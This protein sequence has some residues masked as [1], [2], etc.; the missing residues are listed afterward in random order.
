MGRPLMP[1]QQYVADVALEL[2]PTTGRF[3][4]QLVLV[5]VPRQSG[6]T[7]LFG[8]VMQHRAL[9]T[10]RGRVWFTMQTQKDAVDWLTNEHWPL[11]APLGTAVS[12][13]RAIGSEAI[14]WRHSGALVRPFPPNP[15]GLHGKVSDL[16]VIDECW[17]FDW[18][19]GQQL[20]QAIVPTQAT[21][22]DAQVWKV[23]TAGD[24]SS[25]WW[26]GAV[27]SG[28][29]AALAGRT[30]GV[31]YFDWSC[32]V[33]LDATD[34]RSWDQ[35]HPA[36]GRTIGA[37]N[38]RAALELL[39]PDEF[40]RAYGNRWTQ[41]VARVIPLDAWRG[42]ADPEAPMPEAGAVALAFDVAVD[43]SDACVVAAW[44]DST[45]LGHLEVAD[46]RPGVGWLAERVP[47]LVDR[48]RPA[49]VWYDAA[50]PALDVADV[51]QRSGLEVV[52]LKAR[53]Y[54]AAC[55]GLLQAIIAD[56]PGVRIR[57]HP[58]L[59]AAASAAA[60]RALGDAWAW[61]RRQTAVSI[62]PLTA[63]TVGLWGWDH[64]PADL[65]V[66]RVW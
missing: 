49:G 51:L 56:P 30:D 18:V 29:A 38:M 3:V 58:A 14:R 7:T 2:D 40:A 33:E 21:R 45:G 46:Y 50:G 11:L 6:K 43:R 57:P 44:R 31:A 4:Y 64:Q 34:P 26:L 25:T 1:W 48:W 13:R 17:A 37:P 62:A 16:V 61:S 65:G 5:T 41:T 35:Y 55:S 22:P 9:S 15:T 20:D 27:E 63:A 32:P 39:G 12:L 53:D 19:K 23:S 47:E 52:G 36:Y 60:R 28:R 24:A 59:D 42:V 8:A 54:A 10:P 66:F